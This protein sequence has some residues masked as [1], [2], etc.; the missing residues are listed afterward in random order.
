MPKPIHMG[1]PR[2][3]SQQSLSAMIHEAGPARGYML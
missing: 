2:K 3:S 1:L